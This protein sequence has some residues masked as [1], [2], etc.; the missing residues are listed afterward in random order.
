MIGGLHD[1]A[2]TAWWGLVAPRATERRRLEIA[3]AVI[4]REGAGE[5]G[6]EVCLTIR[7]DLFGW[8]LPGGTLER[9]ESPAAALARE[10]HEETGLEIEIEREVG[11]WERTGFRPHTAH[12]YRC[13]AVGGRLRPSFETPRVAWFSA[14]RP[15]A[16]LFPWYH[17][18]LA[19]AL[20]PASSAPIRVQ[21]RQ[22]LDWMWRAMRID[23]AMRW[24][25]LPDAAS[26]ADLHSS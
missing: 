4:L 9:G 1:Y 21:E 25:G 8:E 16:S 24:Q 6:P 20:A 13:R 7:A 23:L 26:G 15:P 17:A 19:R 3:Q 2:R 18:P 5:D 12:L 11:S 22:G 14:A 10:V